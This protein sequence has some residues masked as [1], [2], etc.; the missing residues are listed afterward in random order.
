MTA[1]NL[2]KRIGIFLKFVHKISLQSELP[3]VARFLKGKASP[4]ELAEIQS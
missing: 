4:E 2:M 3:V 1:K